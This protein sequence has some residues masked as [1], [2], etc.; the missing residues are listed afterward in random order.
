MVA[1]FRRNIYLK[2]ALKIRTEINDNRGLTDSYYNLSEYYKTRDINLSNKYALLTYQYS[3][4]L[5]FVDIRLGAL[6]LLIQN[7]NGNQ[8]KK[9]SLLYLHINDSIT[10]VRQK[11]K[12]QFAKIKYDSKKAKDENLKLK[13]QKAENTL[14]LE[15]HKNRTLI[16]FFIVII[17]L[18]TSGF[19]YYYLFTKSKREK[20]KTS[21]DTET[22]ISTK[23]HDE[24]ANDVYQVIAFTETQ[25]LSSANNKEILLTN[26][27]TIYSRTRNISK[28]NSTIETGTPFL[29]N[30]KEMI[31][32]YNTNS[33]NIIING[34]DTINW[35]TLENTKKITVYRVL[36][37]LLVNMKKHSKC[38]IVVLSFKKNKNN[39]HIDYT[40]N[41]VGVTFDKIKMKNGL[42]NIENRIQAINGTV[43]FDTKFDKGFKVTIKFPA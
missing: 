14:Q 30:L 24:L 37:E 12:N 41:G 2:L 16:L 26:L 39:L 19:L 27:D 20:V 25:D 8:S 23:L 21:Y 18:I 3:S 42:E 38:S 31:S 4:K 6:K 15:L 5:N 28:E 10:K 9:Y 7:S 34:I 35:S 32:G 29:Y 40:D 43:A 1:Y 33:I 13:T 36:Q 17:I 11:S 22:R